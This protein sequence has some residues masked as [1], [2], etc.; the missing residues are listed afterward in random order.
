MA[1]KHKRYRTSEKGRSTHHEYM[2][3]YMVSYRTKLKEQGLLDPE[4][5]RRKWREQHQRVRE[6]AF[7]VLGGRCC[8]NCGCSEFS[9][10]EVNHINGGGRAERKA[11]SYRQ[12]YRDISN[13]KVDAKEYNVLCRVC[14][15][16]HYVQDILRV[17][18]HRVIWKGGRMVRQ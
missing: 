11:K 13:G 10:L 7:E 5:E 6:K 3:D 17:S 9:I 18:G 15:A 12:L 8:A 2:R 4:D 14:N 1:E 16:L